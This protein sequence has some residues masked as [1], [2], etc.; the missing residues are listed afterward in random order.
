VCPEDHV[1]GMTM[2][3]HVGMSGAIVKELHQGLHGGLGMLRYEFLVMS[4]HQQQ[5]MGFGVR[6]VEFG[7]KV[8]FMCE[9]AWSFM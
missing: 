3:A 1:T 9:I 6:M 5:W 7:V 4:N 8:N 2:D